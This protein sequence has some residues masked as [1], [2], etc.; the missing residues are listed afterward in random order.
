GTVSAV[1]E[2]VGPIELLFPASEARL[3][4]RLV[5]RCARDALA[6]GAAAAHAYVVKRGFASDVLVSNVLLDSYAKGGSLAAGRQLF[7]EMPDRD[8][9]SWCTVI[10]AHASRGLFIEANGIFK[11]LLSSDQVK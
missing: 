9:A 8:V 6:V 5:R 10:A 3:Y 4:V 7:D 2:I 1:L 11:E